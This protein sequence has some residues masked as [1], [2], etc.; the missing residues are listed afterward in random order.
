MICLSKMIAVWWWW[1]S[2]SVMTWTTACQASLSMEFPWK[3]YMNT[4]VDCHFLLQVVFPTQGLNPGLLHCR[5]SLYKLSHQGTHFKIHLFCLIS[6]NVF[7]FTEP[8][9]LQQNR[10]LQC[11]SHSVHVCLP[12][13]YYFSMTRIKIQIILGSRMITTNRND[14]L[15]GEVLLLRLLAVWHF[16]Y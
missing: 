12:S 5:W 15:I 1:F 6:K 16:R 14:E 3:K 2:F 4:G 10:F 8:K 7:L 9:D 13:F 11:V